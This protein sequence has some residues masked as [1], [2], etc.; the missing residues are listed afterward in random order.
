[1]D[2]SISLVQFRDRLNGN[3]DKTLLDVE[4]GY[5]FDMEFSPLFFLAC[6]QQDNRCRPTLLLRGHQFAGAV[7]NMGRNHKLKV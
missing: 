3:N 6:F 5:E 1:M 2:G 4:N 7:S